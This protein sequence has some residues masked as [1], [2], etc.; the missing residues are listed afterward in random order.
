M[1]RANVFNRLTHAERI[2]EHALEPPPRPR[3]APVPP[4]PRST[5]PLPKPAALATAAARLRRP[6]PMV[7]IPIQP[8]PGHV[9]MLSAN[10]V[11][12][13]LVLTPEQVAALPPSQGKTVPVVIAVGGRQI[14][15]SLSAKSLRKSQA[16]IAEHGAESVAV[17]V[18][19]RLLTDDV[20]ADA[21]IVSNLKKPAPAAAQG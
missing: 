14:R 13:T 8:R 17:I 9:P 1:S 3:P 11:K 10:S 20:L 12:V 7:T 18:Q 2:V 16:I 5:P 19:G 15:A 6:K 4:P 21:G